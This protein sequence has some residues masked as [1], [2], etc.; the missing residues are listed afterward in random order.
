MKIICPEVTLK[1]ICGVLEEAAERSAADSVEPFKQE[2]HE[3]KEWKDF[4]ALKTAMG[5]ARKA[6]T[7]MQRGQKKPRLQSIA[8]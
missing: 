8:K 1:R 2:K 3:T 7:Y 6:P 4:V 5:E